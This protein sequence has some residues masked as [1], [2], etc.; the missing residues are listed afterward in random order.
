MLADKRLGIPFECRNFILQNR[1]GSS[2]FLG[3]NIRPWGFF[4]QINQKNFQINQKKFQI[5]QNKFQINQ[6]KIQTYQPYSQNMMKLII[7]NVN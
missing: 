6:K 4:F 5:N 1:V 7:D 2:H 3:L